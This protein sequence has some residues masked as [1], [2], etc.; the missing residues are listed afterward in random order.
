[1]QCTIV[2]EGS[3]EDW[4]GYLPRVMRKGQSKRPHTGEYV[5]RGPSGWCLVGYA[6]G[7]LLLNDTF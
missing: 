4:Q 7:W 5:G 3:N 6:R 1:V 2:T